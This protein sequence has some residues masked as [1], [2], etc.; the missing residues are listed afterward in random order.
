M[1]KI[2]Y[3]LQN[4]KKNKPMVCCLTNI[5]S[6]DFIC[7]A[8]LSIG[9]A[10]IVSCSPEETDDLIK[11]SKALYINIGTLNKDFIVM[12]E[13]AIASAK[14]YNIPII[15]D[16]VGSGATELRTN[17]VRG[18]LKSVDIVRGNASEII[19]L[20]KNLEQSLGVESS[21]SVESAK[22]IAMEIVK[23]H[24]ICISISGKTDFIVDNSQN[25]SLSFGSEI[26]S[27]ITGMGCSLGGIT[28]A[29]TAVS[30]NYFEAARLAVLYYTICAEIAYQKAQSPASFKTKF[31][32]TLFEQPLDKIKE[33]YYG[34]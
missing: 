2:S 32:D 21:Y 28:A 1:E 22:N 19:S 20:Q 14:T 34:K 25:A 8:L 30:N 3:Y 23:A 9:A 15:L 6:V 13:S 16:P 17:F 31:I 27:K 18:I 33:I 7:N 24:N 12:A 4:I 26:M 11:L 29:F 5:V 10:P